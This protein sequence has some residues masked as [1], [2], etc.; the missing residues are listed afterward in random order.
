[1]R[2]A[3][4]GIFHPSIRYK[5][6]TKI[7]ILSR[8]CQSKRGPFKYIP[9]KLRYPGPGDCYRTIG[10]WPKASCAWASSPASV[11]WAKASW[12]ARKPRAGAA[13]LPY[14]G[15]MKRGHPQDLPS[16]N[17]IP[18]R[19]YSQVYAR[20]FHPHKTIS[21]PSGSAGCKWHHPDGATNS[22]RLRNPALCSWDASPWRPV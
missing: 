18:S 15:G 12:S 19:E 2:R 1:M 14:S 17:K 3:R 4:T 9:R 11:S 13:V 6:T 20:P 16:Q 21:L 10:T 5:Q 22:W 8:L 7:D